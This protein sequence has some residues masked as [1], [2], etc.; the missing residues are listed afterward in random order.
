MILESKNI[1]FVIFLALAGSGTAVLSFVSG[2]NET[3]TNYAQPGQNTHGIIVAEEGSTC[4][5]EK[6][7][8]LLR[9]LKKEGIVNTL[10]PYEKTRV[11]ENFYINNQE[12]F[13][14]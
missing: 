1:V 10:K 4:A 13:S 6:P 12:L 3:I 2:V 7:R 11:I 9:D 14:N 8:L 5:L